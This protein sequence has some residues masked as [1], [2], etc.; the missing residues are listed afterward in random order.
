[1]SITPER[2]E[3]ILNPSANAEI[4]QRDTKAIEENR[5]NDYLAERCPA[6]SRIDL[7]RRLDWEKAMQVAKEL[8][9]ERKSYNILVVPIWQCENESE[10]PEGNWES[11]T[12][13]LADEP[14]VAPIFENAL[15]D[16]VIISA[17]IERVSPSF[18]SRTSAYAPEVPLS[19]R[20]M[21]FA[22]L[23]GIGFYRVL[24]ISEVLPLA[25]IGRPSLIVPPFSTQRVAAVELN[26]ENETH[27]RI[28]TE[29]KKM[30]WI[31]P[32]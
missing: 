23:R 32:E 18:V 19:Y 17:L 31:S 16:S 11:A 20:G 13:I 29:L 10:E 14:S 2:L 28:A 27:E 15:K 3:T 30:S 12:M 26:S 7:F 22:A 25:P 1:L 8:S 6:P 21:F 24:K 4:R 9:I 5:W